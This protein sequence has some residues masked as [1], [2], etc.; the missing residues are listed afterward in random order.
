MFVL[1]LNSVS[2]VLCH[3]VLVGV[4]LDLCSEWLKGRRCGACGN[5][6][7]DL[8]SALWGPGL[9]Y[10]LHSPFRGLW[11][12]ELSIFHFKAWF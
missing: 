10:S 6:G 4:S 12:L 1:K 8:L 2:L 11:L 7:Q 5:F 3:L 9:S